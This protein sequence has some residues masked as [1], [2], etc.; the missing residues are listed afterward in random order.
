MIIYYIAI[1]SILL[2]LY[3]VIVTYFADHPKAYIMAESKAKLGARLVISTT[4]G[5][6]RPKSQL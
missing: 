4:M 3:F 6:V 5:S 1:I 2:I